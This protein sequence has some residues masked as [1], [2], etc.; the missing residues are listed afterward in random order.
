M[1]I[2]VNRLEKK[3]E[4]QYPCLMKWKDGDMIV[5]FR[6]EHSGVVVH[7]DGPIYSSSRVIGEYDE[8]FDMNQFEPFFGSL[9]MEND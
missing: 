1:K 2:I 4:I 3:Q 8:D 9:M 5:L 6:K 7:R